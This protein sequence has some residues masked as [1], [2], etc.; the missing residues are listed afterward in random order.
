MSAAILLLSLLTR[1]WPAYAGNQAS[2][3]AQEVPPAMLGGVGYPVS[4]RLRN[5]GDTRW[6]REELYRLGAAYRLS[7]RWLA[8]ADLGLPSDNAPYGALGAECRLARA[9]GWS[10]AARA[11]LNTR[12]LGEVPGLSGL[13]LGLGVG[14]GKVGTDYAVVPLGALGLTHRVSL[15]L[16]F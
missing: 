13:A 1:A 5:T 16:K 4:V 7:E 15:S 6:T 11:G 3:V 9:E 12:T 8:A 10:V 2:F 14:V